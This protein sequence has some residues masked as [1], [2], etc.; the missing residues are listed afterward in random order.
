[1]SPSCTLWVRSPELSPPRDEGR[2]PAASQIA[3]S[4]ALL[5]AKE[6]THCRAYLGR[7]H[8]RSTRF[9]LG[10]AFLLCSWGFLPFLPKG[11]D[12]IPCAQRVTPTC[13]LPMGLKLVPQPFGVPTV[14]LLTLSAQWEL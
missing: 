1:M 12:E 7:R 14:L 6:G 5:P 8:G 10:S 11:R 2:Q 4:C 13:T 9:S 3:S